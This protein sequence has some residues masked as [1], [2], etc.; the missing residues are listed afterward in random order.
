MY[1][2]MENQIIVTKLS[3]RLHF[4]PTQE[5]VGL[6]TSGFQYQQSESDVCDSVRHEYNYTTEVTARVTQRLH[7]IQG[8]CDNLP[9]S[10]PEPGSD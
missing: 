1:N 10:R 2:R 8:G 3:T 6:V 4:L 5:P 9:Q 7:P